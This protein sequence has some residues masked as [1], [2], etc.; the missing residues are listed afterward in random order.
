MAAR[1]AVQDTKFVE[2]YVTEVLASV[3]RTPVCRSRNSKIPSIQSQANFVL[4]QVGDLG[5]PLSATNCAIEA[6]LFALQL[7]VPPGY[8]ALYRGHA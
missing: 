5:N 3:P 2:D 4:G 8:F 6:S 7:T 1:I